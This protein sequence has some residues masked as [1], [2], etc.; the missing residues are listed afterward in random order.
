M[1]EMKERKKQQLLRR[2]D[3]ATAGERLFWF[4]YGLFLVISILN[5][6]FYYKY[7]EGKPCMCLQIL[8]M[9]LLAGYEYRNGFLKSQ[10]WGPGI[11][12]AL[13][14]AISLRV[15]QG[16][17]T[18]LVAM[19]FPYI[20]CGRRIEFRR[21][22]EMTMKCVL[23]TVAVVV[24]SAWL[25]LIDNVVMYKS[26]RVREFMGFRYALY[27]PAILLN[28]TV[29]WAYLN[30]EKLPLLGVL[31]WGALNWYVYYMTD[32]RVSFLLAELLLV[33]ALLMQWLPR[34]M[35]KLRPL[36]AAL[37]PSFL[38]CGG[39]SVALTAAYDWSVP[40][41]RRVN[42]M[43]D[44]RLN[45]G[46]H[47]MGKYGVRLFGQVI[48]WVGNGLDSAGNSVDSMYDYVDNLYV[49]I[50][51]RYGVV[52]WI[53]ILVLSTWAMY[54]LWKQR[55]YY[56]L[57]VSATVAAHSLLDDLAFGLHYNSFWIAMGFALFV[58]AWTQREKFPKPEE[59][60][61]EGNENNQTHEA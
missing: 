46:R 12:L 58:P 11:V 50:L 54:R 56:I 38:L 2:L 47:S 45:L 6:S 15:S 14:T 37:I 7:Y 36:W 22:L 8:C 52:F 19:M 35:E 28:L 44:G 23:I 3:Q 17:M 61:K 60:D 33:A 39:L 42:G 10:Q 5:N 4:S 24:V 27:L 57:L 55:E 13:L 40:W 41:M 31:S 43:L 59:S 1:D 32:S 34:L 29:I 51:L 18:R 26:G 16:S 9:L 21:I 53:A 49:K 20:Y 48:E 30:R 25:G